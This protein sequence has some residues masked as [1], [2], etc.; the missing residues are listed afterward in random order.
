MGEWSQVIN[1]FLQ[2]ALGVCRS[3][4]AVTAPESPSCTVQRLLIQQ[5]WLEPSYEMIRVASESE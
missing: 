1:G 2:E 4:Y 3:I 5:Q